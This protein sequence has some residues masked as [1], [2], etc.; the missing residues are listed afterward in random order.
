MRNSR[1]THRCAIL[2]IDDSVYVRLGE[3]GHGFQVVALGLNHLVPTVVDIYQYMHS[4]MGPNHPENRDAVFK[5]ICITDS[6]GSNTPR[7]PALLPHPV[8][9]VQLA[10]EA[11]Q[12]KLPPP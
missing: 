11:L 10:L 3:I 4:R 6:F 5:S 8:Q 7:L 12:K 9:R 2:Y 1:L